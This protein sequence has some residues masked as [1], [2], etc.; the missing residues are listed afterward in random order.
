M[1]PIHSPWPIGWLAALAGFAAAP[2]LAQQPEL[3]PGGWD[4]RLGLGAAIGPEYPGGRSLEVAPVPL[5]DAAYRVGL[6]GLDTLFLNTRDGLGLVA[7]RHG[8]F[9]LGGAI[10]YAPGR[11]Q[12]DAARLKGLGD[13]EGAAR[14]SLF[15]R[16]DFGAFGASLR[17]DRALGDQEGTTVTLGASYRHRLTPTLSLSG[18]ASLVWADGDH[19]QQW[20]G[21]DRLQA[22]RSGLP[23][24]RAEGGLR[25]ASA[26]LGAAYVLSPRWTFNA[27]VGAVQLLGDAA[28][29]PIVERKTQP[30]GLVGATYKF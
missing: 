15:L 16:G 3:A 20:Y 13:I 6:P 24:Y 7:L 17:A 12:D 2:A 1:R 8:P 14:A 28:D 25:S 23:Q 30:F 27:S 11:D 4:L 5:V 9:S 26:S 22:A 21:L 18:Q 19:M 10:G 29:S